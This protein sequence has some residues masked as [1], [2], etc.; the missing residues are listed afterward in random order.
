MSTQGEQYMESRIDGLK[1][2]LANLEAEKAAMMDVIGKKHTELS[3]TVKEI[4]EHRDSLDNKIKELLNKQVEVDKA[5]DAHNAALS[6]ANEATGKLRTLQSQVD[7]ALLRNQR[8]E[9]RLAD[10]EKSLRERDQAVS[11]RE[12]LV[13]SIFASI[14]NIEAK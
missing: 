5:K 14:R 11:K 13:R 12:E 1:K 6:K 3:K 10:V 2:E 7:E 4:Q 9:A 8:L